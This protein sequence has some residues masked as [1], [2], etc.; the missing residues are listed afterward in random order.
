MGGGIY[1][2][3]GGGGGD[4]LGKFHSIRY[5]PFPLDMLAIASCNAV[6]VKH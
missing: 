2:G 6:A 5:F 1:P 4:L 3:G